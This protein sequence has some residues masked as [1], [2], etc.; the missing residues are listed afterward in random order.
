MKWSFFHTDLG[1]DILLTTCLTWKSQLKCSCTI[2]NLTYVLFWTCA[3][4]FEFYTIF[5]FDLILD[6]FMLY[7]NLY[8]WYVCRLCVNYSAI[9]VQTCG[10]YLKRWQRNKLWCGRP[11]WTNSWRDSLATCL[12]KYLIEPNFKVDLMK[13]FSI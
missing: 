5:G 10:R 1:Y 6:W 4:F 7:V 3:R 13:E 8:L 9:L 2:I 11:S 12:V